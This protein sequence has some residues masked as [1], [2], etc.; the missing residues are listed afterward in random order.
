MK[1][2][3]VACFAF[4]LSILVVISG[5]I[6]NK[7][8]KVFK[9]LKETKEFADTSL[10]YDASLT[11]NDDL[12]F[13]LSLSG[14]EEALKN[15]QTEGSGMEYLGCH[16]TQFT[17]E[18]LGVTQSHTSY[19]HVI[20]LVGAAPVEINGREEIFY[21]VAETTSK[22]SDSFALKLVCHLDFEDY[23]SNLDKIAKH[24]GYALHKK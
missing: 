4:A 13:V 15:Y 23:S 16:E 7:G 22:R 1:K 24:S 11:V 6:F 14:Y 9:Y 17:T 19:E 20:K 5:C 21:L 12:S 18:W 8:A 10:D 2:L 3:S